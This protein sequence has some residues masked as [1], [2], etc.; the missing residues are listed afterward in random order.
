[1]TIETATAHAE[2]IA[3][4][5]TER[6]NNDAPFG[7]VTSHG[8][9]Y[10]TLEEATADGV[11]EYEIEE[12]TALDYLEDALDIEYRV[13]ANR[14]YKSA[15]ILVGFGGPNVWIDTKTATVNV[16]WWSETVSRSIPR[17]FTDALDEAL[18]ELFAS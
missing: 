18:E 11:E 17:E 13:N 1:M 5:I 10:D 7:Y 9:H 12:A 14:E 15:E 16:A 8:E 3:N 4:Q 2:S 6:V